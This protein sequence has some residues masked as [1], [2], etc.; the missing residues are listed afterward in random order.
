VKYTFSR[1]LRLL[2]ACGL[3]V[4]AMSANALAMEGIQSPYLKGYRDFLTGVLP[5][6]GVQVRQDLYVYSGSERST[7]PQGQLAVSY[8]T[9]TNILGATIVTPYRVFGGDF[10]F[11]VRGA[12]S[13]AT[14]TQS[15]AAII[16]PLSNSRS[17]SLGAFNDVVISP[18]IVGWHAGNWHWNVSAS[19]WLPV[20]AYDKTRLVNTG[21]NYVAVSPQLGVTYLDPKSGW[22][23]SG[24][25]IFVTSYY[26]PATNYRSGDAIHVDLAA[27]K[28]LTSQFKLGVVGYWTQQLNDDSGAGAI[29]GG[30]KVRVAG[31][32]PG[33]T[34]TFFVGAVPV[35]L[36]GKYYREFDAQNTTQG[37]AGTLSMRVRF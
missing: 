28:M 16:P 21:K 23:F 17:G 9:V 8:K 37:D 12:Y 11:A 18:V 27:G 36:V 1:V 25:G 14:A 4:A 3:A 31:V 34:F 20:G 22:E 24:A 5:P 2:A 29:F 26:N 19:V 30:R 33:A 35:T 7:I 10:G 13:D 6:P 32:G 15:L